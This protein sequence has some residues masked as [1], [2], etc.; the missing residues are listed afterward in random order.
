VL[1]ET[2][3]GPVDIDEALL[4][5]VLRGAAASDLPSPDAVAALRQP[6]LILAWDGDPG[7][8]VS[9]AE[10]LRELIPDSTLEI[11]RTPEALRTWGDRTVRFLTG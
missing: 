7:H 3:E 4:P 9:T 5:T 8:P 11:A 2:P 10:R 1:A 6:A